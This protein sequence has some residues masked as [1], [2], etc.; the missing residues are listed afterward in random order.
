MQIWSISSLRTS[1][2]PAF[3]EGHKELS[4]W[5]S[6]ERKVKE[7]EQKRRKVEDDDDE[8]KDKLGIS[9]NKKQCHAHVMT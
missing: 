1:T 8:L 2:T 9:G 7:N 3:G 4:S 5:K 6:T